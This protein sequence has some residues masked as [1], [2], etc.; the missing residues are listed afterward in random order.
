[1]VAALTGLEPDRP[2]VALVTLNVD[3]GGSD[4]A[5]A[6]LRRDVAELSGEDWDAAILDLSAIGAL[7]PRLAG[8]LLFAV[9]QLLKRVKRVAFVGRPDD[10]RL[11]V[12]NLDSVAPFFPSAQEAAEHYRQAA[13]LT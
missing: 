12:K 10:V 6:Q 2:R 7:H 3:D 4:G 11:P 13:A 5:V 8:G 1:M 9:H